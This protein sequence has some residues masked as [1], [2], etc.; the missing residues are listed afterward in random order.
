MSGITKLIPKVF[1][2]TWRFKDLKWKPK[3][4]GGLKKRAA[5]KRGN[6]IDSELNGEVLFEKTCPETKLIYKVL[7]DMKLDIVATQMYVKQGSL[8][9]FLDMVVRHQETGQQYIIEIKRGCEYRRCGTQD[10][11]LRFQNKTLNDCLL[12]QHQMQVLIGRWL[13]GDENR[14][15]V[16]LIYVNETR[17]EV[18]QEYEFEVELLQAG[19]N[20]LMKSAT[21]KQKRRVYYRSKRKLIPSV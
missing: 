19:K 10:G 8:K 12:H 9:T 18:L 6:R 11:I 21:Q 14:T 4:I 2:P 7:H 13:F 20:E 16:L 15:G 3:N 1:A 5:K 17:V